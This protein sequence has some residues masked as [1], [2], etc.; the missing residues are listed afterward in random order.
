[1]GLDY[2]S[3]SK[4]KAPSIDKQEEVIEQEI[5]EISLHAPKEYSNHRDQILECGPSDQR[6]NQLNNC[7]LEA[8]A[9]VIEYRSVPYILFGE[10]DAKELANAFVRFPV[11]IKPILTCVNVAQRA[12]RRDLG[13]DI[14]TYANRITE[15]QA[16]LLAGYIKPILPSTMAIPSL[17]ELDRYF[18]TDKELRAQKGNWEKT[19][20]NHINQISKYQFKKRRFECDG[21]TF[22]IDAAHPLDL[23]RS[24]ELAID[25]KR[26][27]SQRD[28]HKRADEILNKAVKFKKA[29]PQ[30]RFFV[31]IYYP[32]PNQ[33]INAQ[34]RL[35]SAYID[36]LF[37]AGESES[38]IASAADMLIGKL[39]LDK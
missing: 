11:I 23:S 26:I 34:S 29:F 2:M 36:G 9:Q 14:N 24:I 6:V 15:K 19:V 25:I 3:D 33:H 22:E 38:S 8:F 10:L 1:M 35:S 20:T 16:S 17:L 31:I 5:Q 21:E 7:L 32:F 4:N 13:I 28:I 27:E 12:I 37:F 18:W 39:G 30:G